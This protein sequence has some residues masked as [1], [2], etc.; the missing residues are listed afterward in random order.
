[1][2]DG[3]VDVFMFDQ[4]MLEPTLP[5]HPSIHFIHTYIRTYVHES[6]GSKAIVLALGSRL[7]S[8]HRRSKRGLHRRR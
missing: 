7:G 6:V 1:M 8:A 3:G 2:A 5:A 4:S